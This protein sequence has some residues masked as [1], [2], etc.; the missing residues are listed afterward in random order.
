MSLD[1]YEAVVPWRLLERCVANNIVA[2]VEEACGSTDDAACD[3][4]TEFVEAKLEMVRAVRL[5]QCCAD[6]SRVHWIDTRDRL[7]RDEIHRCLSG[8]VGPRQGGSR[9]D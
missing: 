4:A 6:V 3:F 9:F 1:G 7:Q 2:E 5:F 8:G